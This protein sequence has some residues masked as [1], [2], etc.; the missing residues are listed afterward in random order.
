M[1]I[2][3]YVY[4]LK[5]LYFVDGALLLSSTN[6]LEN[7]RWLK[8]HPKPTRTLGSDLWQGYGPPQSW[9][10]SLDR[11]QTVL[12]GWQRDQ[13]LQNN[14]L[15][16]IGTL[17]MRPKTSWKT[18]HILIFS[19]PDELRPQASRSSASPSLISRTKPH[20]F[21]RFGSAWYR[22]DNRWHLATAWWQWFN[23]PRK[24]SMMLHA[25]IITMPIHFWISHS[26][27]DIFGLGTRF[28]SAV[29]GTIRNRERG[30]CSPTSPVIIL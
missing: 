11:I 19:E 12:C 3:I 10:G 21:G 17:E 18:L 30:C 8:T 20:R 5:L 2:Y 22:E 1:Y 7:W 6:P 26:T 24:G 16:N 23:D 29:S 28:L 13:L 9:E 27:R 14:S 15:K 4:Y 25:T